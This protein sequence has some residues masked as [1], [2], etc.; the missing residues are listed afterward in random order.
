MTGVYEVK[1]TA[2]DQWLLATYDGERFFLQT[3][4]EARRVFQY[5]IAFFA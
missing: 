1:L 3:G 2:E 4:E 5:R